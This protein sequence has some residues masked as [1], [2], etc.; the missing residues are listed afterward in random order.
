VGSILVCGVFKGDISKCLSMFL[1]QCSVR[2]IEVNAGLCITPGFSYLHV[3][4]SKSN[5]GSQR[6]VGA[7]GAMQHA[8]ISNV[9]SCWSSFLLSQGP[10]IMCH[11]LLMRGNNFGKTEYLNYVCKNIKY[12]GEYFPSK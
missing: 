11:Y 9:F 7:A 8:E 2:H 10:V 1:I 5:L 4:K 3:R 6:P 12:K